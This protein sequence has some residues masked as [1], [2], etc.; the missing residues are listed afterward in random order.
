MSRCQNCGS[1]NPGGALFC[2]KCGSSFAPTEPTLNG[3]GKAAAPDRFFKTRIATL[4]ILAIAFAI[5]VPLA[6]TLGMSV[7]VEEQTITVEPD[8]YHAMRFPVYGYGKFE[9]SYTKND[10]SSMYLLE[11]GASD[12]DEFVSGEPYDYRRYV[13]LDGRGGGGSGMSGFIW[14]R[15]LVLVNEGVSPASVELEAES[16]ALASLL[17]AG[18]LLLVEVAIALSVYYILPRLSSDKRGSEKTP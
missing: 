2:E 8:S 16:I 17:V 11:L 9:F 6:S 18:P 7:H 1:D 3:P 15:Y 13:S 5:I 4:F 12:Y 14:V 10:S